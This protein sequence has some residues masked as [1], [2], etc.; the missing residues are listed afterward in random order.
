MLRA[1]RHRIVKKQLR[2]FLAQRLYEPRFPLRI[3][4]LN[5]SLTWEKQ[6]TGRLGKTVSF[7]RFFLFDLSLASTGLPLV[8]QNTASQ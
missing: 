8:V 4:S 3:D 5:D 6:T 7:F 2:R 1:G